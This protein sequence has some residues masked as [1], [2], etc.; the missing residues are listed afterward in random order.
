MIYQDRRGR[1]HLQNKFFC[2]A[3]HPCL[4]VQSKQT[5]YG[6]PC[7]LCFNSHELEGVPQAAETAG[8][9]SPVAAV[10]VLHIGAKGAARIKI[11]CQPAGPSGG[12]ACPS[13]RR[14]GSC[15]AGKMCELVVH[16]LEAASEGVA[17]QGTLHELSWTSASQV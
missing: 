10:H 17:S 8:Q 14:Q 7:Q 15:K 4:S 6:T 16:S 2:Q 5:V 13:C 9:Q 11:V 1:R 12:I 3:L